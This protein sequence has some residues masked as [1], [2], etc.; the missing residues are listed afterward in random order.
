LGQHVKRLT[1]T[2]VNGSSEGTYKK[3]R[4]TLKVFIYTYTTHTV[5]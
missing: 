2:N 3:K 5:I 4:K 1:Y